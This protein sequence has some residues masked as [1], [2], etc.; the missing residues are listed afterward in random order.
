[1]KFTGMLTM[2]FGLAAMIAGIY[3]GVWLMLV[4]GIVDV[5]NQIKAPET[6][7]FTIA[8]AIV[9]IIFFE[10]PV[11]LGFMVGFLFLAAG[12]GEAS[13]IRPV[14]RKRKWQ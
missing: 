12:L 14:I 2:L 8:V 7:A 1:M 6:D 13:K 10:I 9:K 5:I 11:G 3:T 4:G